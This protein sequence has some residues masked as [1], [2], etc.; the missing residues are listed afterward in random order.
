MKGAE[1]AMENPVSARSLQHL[2]QRVIPDII[3]E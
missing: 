1:F 3:R 2:W